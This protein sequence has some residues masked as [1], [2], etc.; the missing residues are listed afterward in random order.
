MDV[1]DCHRQESGNVTSTR[2]RPDN[3]AMG[4][5]FPL[6]VAMND[7][8]VKGNIKTRESVIV[9]PLSDWI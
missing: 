6:N 4:Q 7:M 3:R 8:T 1:S 2:R 9:L 5:A